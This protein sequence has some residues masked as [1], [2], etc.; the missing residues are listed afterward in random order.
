MRTRGVGSAKGDGA[1][2]G[3]GEEGERFGSS[4]DES[5][6][7]HD[8]WVEKVL[9]DGFGEGGLDERM[10]TECGRCKS[11]HTRILRVLECG[12]MI[13]VNDL[14]LH[15][16][17]L[18][19]PDPH[20]YGAADESP[21]S[22]V[23]SSLST[24]RSTQV[25]FIQNT[26]TIHKDKIRTKKKP[27][28]SKRRRRPPTPRAHNRVHNP[29]EEPIAHNDVPQAYNADHRPPRRSN[30]HLFIQHTRPDQSIKLHK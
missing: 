23:F 12:D 4:G 19:H 29:L 25:P 11:L 20:T 18:Q 21:T 1:E 15:D 27:R 22:P 9:S 26:Y 7:M 28:A 13:S 5:L 6:R 24:P 10:G 14:I 2:V 30:S 8:F 16:A 3:W 17:H